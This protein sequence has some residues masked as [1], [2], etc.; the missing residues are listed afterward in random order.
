[1]RRTRNRGREKMQILLHHFF[2]P[3]SFFFTANFQVTYI[4]LQHANIN[5]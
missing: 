5:A 1:M 4:T 2:L 3:L